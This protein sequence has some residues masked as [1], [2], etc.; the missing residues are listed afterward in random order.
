MAGCV[1]AA[2]GAPNGGGSHVAAAPAV[3]GGDEATCAASD[4]G[5][6]D[7]GDS[8][9]EAAPGVDG[10]DESTCAASD[11]GVDGASEGAIVK[12]A[13]QAALSQTNKPSCN[14]THNEIMAACRDAAE[15]AVKQGK[16]TEVYAVAVQMASL[17][18]NGEAI[19]G[20]FQD[21]IRVYENSFSV[22]H[23]A[24][25]GFEL[26]QQDSIAPMQPAAKPGS[27]QVESRI[28]LPRHHR[29]PWTR[30]LIVEIFVSVEG[31]LHMERTRRTVSSSDERRSDK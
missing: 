28:K 24:D 6:D 29:G 3:D 21:V 18:R 15:L 13:T 5:E 26:S 9:V 12:A 23:T 1:D 17:L 25:V 30:R 2:A 11:G 8:H 20:D 7:G 27:R 14:P 10:G 16:Q 22:R 19:S 31:L 4:G